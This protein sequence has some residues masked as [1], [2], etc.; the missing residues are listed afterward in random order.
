MLF[1]AGF[2]YAK[3]PTYEEYAAESVTVKKNHVLVLEGKYYSIRTILRN[4]AKRPVN[5]AG[6]YI[7]YTYG[8]GGGCL[9]G[10]V[11]DATSGRVVSDFPS[12]YDT[13]D[14]GDEQFDINYHSNSKLL[15]IKGKKLAL[16]V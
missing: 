13:S 10:G 11:I 1:F 4:A 16:L 8:C 6:H 14:E 2:V 9:D 5:F 3:L 12:T 7:L 15:I